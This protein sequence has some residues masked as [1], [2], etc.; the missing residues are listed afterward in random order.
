MEIKKGFFQK[1]YSSPVRSTNKVWLSNPKNS[2]T[3]FLLFVK[4]KQSE[5]NKIFLLD[6]NG[7]FCTLKKVQFESKSLLRKDRKYE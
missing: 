4:G 6:K 2:S 3:F 5:E 7:Y 1:K